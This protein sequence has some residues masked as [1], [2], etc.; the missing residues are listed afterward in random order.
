M[1][2]MVADSELFSDH[3]SY[4]FTCPHLSSKTMRWCS[5]DQQFRQSGAFFLAQAGW[6]S[7]RR[8]ASQAFYSLLFGT[9]HPLAYGPFR[10]SQSV[11]YLRLFPTPLFELE[12][13]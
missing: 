2:R 4:P 9:L 13:A 6:C 3:L 8:R 7:G 10:N 11:G 5:L 12:G 1:S